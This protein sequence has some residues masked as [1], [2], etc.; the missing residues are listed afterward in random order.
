MFFVVVS[1]NSR[2]YFEQSHEFESGLTSRGMR[3]CEAELGVDSLEGDVDGESDDT[4]LAG[5]SPRANP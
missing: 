2:R 1:G 3:D 5:L 4:V